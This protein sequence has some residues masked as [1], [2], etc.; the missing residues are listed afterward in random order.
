MKTRYMHTVNGQPAALRSCGWICKASRN[1]KLA[2]SLRQIQA[3]QRASAAR[4]GK[5]GVRQAISQLGY[6]QVAV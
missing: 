2:A 4:L 1:I 3:D 5:M 6:L